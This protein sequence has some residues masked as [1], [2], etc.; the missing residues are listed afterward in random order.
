MAAGTTP[1][2]PITPYSVIASLAAATACTTRGPTVTASLSGANILAFVPISTNGL[3]IDSI[4]VKACSTSIT[5]ATT[6]NIVGIWLWDGTT[7]YLYD[8]LLVTAV[9]PSTSVAS[10]VTSKSYT[11]LVLPSTFALYASVTVTTTAATTALSV[12][13]FGGAY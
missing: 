4:Q 10:F 11:N 9:T 2:F 13:A 5:A 6:A 8:E 3:R 12:Q 1:I 7:A